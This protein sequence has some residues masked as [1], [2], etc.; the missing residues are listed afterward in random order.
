[1][2]I[3]AVVVPAPEVVPVLGGEV[4]LVEVGPGDEMAAVVG[5]QIDAVGLVVGRDDDAAEVE[6]AV[7]AQVLLVD[8]QHVG[9]RG[10]VGLH[11]VVEREAVDVAEVARLADAQDHAT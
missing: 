3:A 8:A 1:M 9:R 11:V 10:G 2:A 4:V 5:R 6:D 7:L